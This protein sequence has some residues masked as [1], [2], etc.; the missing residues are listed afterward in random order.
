MPFGIVPPLT[1]RERRNSRIVGFSDYCLAV[2]LQQCTPYPLMA[3][4]H[5]RSCCVMLRGFSLVLLLKQTCPFSKRKH[6]KESCFAVKLLKAGCLFSFSSYFFHSWCVLYEKLEHRPQWPAAYMYYNLLEKNVQAPLKVW[7]N[8]S[9]LIDFSKFLKIMRHY[10]YAFFFW[11]MW[12][13]QSEPNYA[14]LLPCIIPET[15]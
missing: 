7:K 13:M 1:T 9:L 10:M 11:N 15:L 4:F 12:I 6:R 2:C 8:H 14:I 3:D 5:A